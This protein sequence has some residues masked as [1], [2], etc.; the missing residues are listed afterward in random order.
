MVENEGIQGD[1]FTMTV[2]D[3][4]SELAGDKPRY[5]CDDREGFLSA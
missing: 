2:E 5:G 3:I 4:D 1:Y